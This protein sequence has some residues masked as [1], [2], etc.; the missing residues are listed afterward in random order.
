MQDFELI[1]VYRK[2]YYRRREAARVA[3]GADIKKLVELWYGTEKLCAQEIC[4]RLKEK[5]ILFT[6]RSI[7]RIANELGIIRNVGDSFRN[8]ASKG[9]VKW[10]FKDPRFKSHRSWIPKKLRM[11]VLRRDDYRCVLCG[12]DAKISILEIDHIIPLVKKGATKL[13]N[14]RVLCNPCNV[15]K[16]ILDKER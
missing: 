2:D 8:A 4:D 13:N 15:G 5:D 9:R 12:T 16:A 10:A 6:P 1:R 11:Q 3:F 14:L 7:Q